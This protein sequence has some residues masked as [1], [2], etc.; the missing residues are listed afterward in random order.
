[1]HLICAGTGTLLSRVEEDSPEKKEISRVY[2][3][4][5][6][7]TEDQF[8]PVSLGGMGNLGPGLQD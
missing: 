3:G 7:L 4:G 8:V 5:G 6:I 1:M 2:S